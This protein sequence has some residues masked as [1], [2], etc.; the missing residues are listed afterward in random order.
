MFA[1]K[2][3]PKQTLFRP[4][5]EE[6]QRTLDSM[7]GGSGGRGGGGGGGGGGDGDG[8]GGSADVLPH[9]R[10]IEIDGDGDAWW[11]APPPVAAAAAAA[12]RRQAPAAVHHH[13]HPSK[14]QPSQHVASTPEGQYAGRL[15]PSAMGT[16]N[17][18]GL[19]RCSDAN[20]M[21]LDPHAAQS[22]VYPGQLVRRDYQYNI[23]RDAL[24]TNSLVC[25]P[26]G[27]GKTLI[28]AVVMYNFY[29]WFP[30]GKVVFLAPTRPLVDQQKAACRDICGIPE[31][32][33][34]VLMGST[35]KD[36]S[37]TR[38][39]FWDQKRVFFCTPQ[40]MENDIA[41]SVLPAKDVVCLVIDEAHR[42][43]GKHAYCGVVRMLWDRN[44]SFR[45]LALTATPGHD[46][47]DVQQ[48]VRNLNIGRIDFRSD[49][50]VD[51]KRHTHNRS[52]QLESVKATRAISEVQDMLRD[53][54]R[55]MLKTLTS[56][57]A[58]PTEGVKMA[59]FVE[60]TSKDI[61]QPFTIQLAQRD[62]QNGN[63]AV[64]PAKKNY[65]FSLCLQS[66]FIAR[67]NALLSGYSAQQAVDYVEDQ[68]TKGYIGALFGA[69]PVMREVLDMLRS[70][71]G[72][73]AHHS[74]KLARL[75]QIIRR[76][77]ATNNPATRAIVFT[78]YRDSVRDI[79]RALRE[80]T[81]TTG[82]GNNLG[83]GD[84]LV[85]PEKGQKT[86]TGMFSAASGS[87]GGSGDTAGVPPEVPD[88]AECRIKV[89][90]F[91]GQGDS[92]KGGGGGGAK[93]AGAARGTK[94]QSQKE[95]KAVL[96]AFRHGS[97]NTIVATS[98]G[99]EGLDIPAVDLIV[100]FDVVDTIRT[101]Q[102][103][104]R[105]G[106]AR[107]G[108]VVVLALEGREAEKFSKEQGK[109]EHLLRSLSDPGR[110]FQLCNDCP[111]MLPA[112]LDPRCE[113]KELGPTPE[114]LKAKREMEA[115]G[116]SGKKRKGARGGAG[117]G[118]AS[119]FSIRPW[120]APLTT[121]EHS[122][123]QAYDCAPRAMGRIDMQ[124][125]APLQRRPTPVFSVPHG[126]MCVA[127]MR[128]MSAAQGLPPPLDVRGES[129]EGGAIAREEK[130]KADAEA[131]RDRAHA[132][133]NADAPT[134][135]FYAPPVEWDDDEWG[136]GGFV[137]AAFDDDVGGGG[138]DDD[139][140][141]L[142]ANWD[143]QRSHGYEAPILD[144]SA[145]KDDGPRASVSQAPTELDERAACE[146]DDDDV[147]RSI[148]ASG[149]HGGFNGVGGGGA[150]TGAT[151]RLDFT[152]TLVDPSPRRV[153]ANEAEP[154]ENPEC[155]VIGC[156]DPKHGASRNDRTPLAQLT[157]PSQRPGSNAM[158][159]QGASVHGDPL[160]GEE[161]DDVF[162]T[163]PAPVA[164]PS[165]SA[166]ES[167][168]QRLRER[169]SQQSQQQR[170]HS[171][172]QSQSQLRRQNTT[173]PEAQAD[174]PDDDD[175]TIAD[176]AFHI[177]QK[178]LAAAAKKRAT[179]SAE[180]AAKASASKSKS[181]SVSASQMPPPP[182]RAT[183]REASTPGFDVAPTVDDAVTPGAADG[184]WGTGDAQDDAVGGWG[185]T[186]SGGGGGGG[187]GV[188]QNTQTS[189]GGWGAP[190][191]QDDAGVGWGASQGTQD[192]AGGGWGGVSDAGGDAGWGGGSPSQ[193][194]DDAEG[195]WGDPPDENDARGGAP[196]TDPPPAPPASTPV[197]P[198]PD[199]DDLMVLKRRKRVAAPAPSP[200]VEPVRRRPPP[201]PPPSFAPAGDDDD[202]DGWRRGG[203][204]KRADVLA[205]KRTKRANAAKQAAVHR[206][207]DDVASG[208]D[209]DDDDDDGWNTEDE[210]FVAATQG[211][212][213]DA[214]GDEPALMHQQLALLADAHT[215]LD[216]AGV[217]GR[218][219]GP[220]VRRDVADTPPGTTPGTG[221]SGGGG[222]DAASQYG[223]SWI[224]DDEEATVLETQF[225]D[226][227]DASG[228]LLGSDGN[229]ERCARCERGGVLVCCDACPGAYHLACVGLA[230]TPPGAWL[231]PACERR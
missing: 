167:A 37:G 212:A 21:L 38:R 115:R 197:Q 24:T 66:Y 47:A 106:R 201:P 223:G 116:S 120:D 108:K 20:G 154:C 16:P 62:L 97:L 43:K 14:W 65:A 113:L 129:I 147:T 123:L 12:P 217:V 179:A 8:D 195:G 100:F 161:N 73:G 211:D 63:T 204:T 39:A 51:V 71:A 124:N 61:P 230:E 107:D 189:G 41:S 87:G 35:K 75:T 101:I 174:V 158:N 19:I 54:L 126:R 96:D 82:G 49:K 86:V 119:A 151:Q 181:K 4:G 160:C 69:S 187:W 79:V 137:P 141:P 84:P 168:R 67:L 13:T 176:I 185:G 92:S 7:F 109:Y 213:L 169:L 125:A 94:G 164:R 132:E 77:F 93:G 172:S 199:S 218:R 23:T 122:L 95:Q 144:A 148:D 88:G 175:E 104:G 171:Q 26:T 194:D 152:A 78:S 182:P 15:T 155:A 99:E 221:R 53:V 85:D 228:E 207:M 18:Q 29:R 11:S 157:P 130:A 40:T 27:L 166:A 177:K 121:V 98:I 203:A 134:T 226:D 180:K 222:G 34:C 1:A 64:P 145:V 110:C 202:D 200:A 225:G 131:A 140:E 105:T 229:M 170:A 173:Q 42:A 214:S 186:Q 112:G 58:L 205:A 219:F 220:R 10:P 156:D 25:L 138:I 127:L 196:G 216:V 128:A 118:N 188:S 208:D 206:F 74:P 162:A 91:I 57:G 90:E 142:R 80:V 117:R 68:N 28:A 103:M 6:K 46:I 231:C 209:D 17:S 184:W 72:H 5:V 56:M 33:I 224:D 55:P 50:D 22:Y 133:A 48:V 178:K 227:D 111:R 215:P 149:S 163:A 153:V 150:H 59:R 76:H 198:T 136:D 159:T 81:V 89:A 183:V 210:A 9:Q 139:D 135:A 44:V 3:G 146:Y 165:P 193:N 70:M 114:A 60:G 192:S 45:L 32:D 52:I 143:S 2:G 36:E 102:R 31:N 190:A 30:K 191:T 83:P